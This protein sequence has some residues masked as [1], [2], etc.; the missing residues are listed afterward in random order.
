MSRGES[1]KRI[2]KAKYIETLIKLKIN[3]SIVQ[4]Y[5]VDMFK[6]ALLCMKFYANII[7][8]LT[9]TVFY[10]HNNLYHTNP[11]CQLSLWVETSVPREKP[12]ILGR[13][14]TDIVLYIH[15]WS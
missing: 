14:L 3:I 8:Y 1:F 5:T 13:A 4:I 12:V 6:C 11:T 7:I 2:I 10:F 15:K 9:L